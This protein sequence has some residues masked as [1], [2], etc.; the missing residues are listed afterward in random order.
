MQALADTC[1]RGWKRQRIVSSSSRSLT[2]ASKHNSE[3]RVNGSSITVLSC[4]RFFQVEQQAP[5][6]EEKLLDNSRTIEGLRQERALLA[7][8]HFELQQHLFEASKV[9]RFRRIHNVSL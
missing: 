6:L 7:D 1:L 5:H 4:R 3:V 2:S 8:K 9:M